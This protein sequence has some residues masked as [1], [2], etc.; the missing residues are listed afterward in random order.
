MR[1][2]LVL[3]TAHGTEPERGMLF[4]GGNCDARRV[5]LGLGV[6]KAR[7]AL[8]EIRELQEKPPRLLLNDHCQVCE[9]RKRCH[10]EATA[11]DDLSLLRGMS[12]KEV[13]KYSR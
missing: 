2:Y 3:G 5:K 1:V 4:H 11:T 7:R 6:A 10:A 8:A 12:E 13:R 9:F